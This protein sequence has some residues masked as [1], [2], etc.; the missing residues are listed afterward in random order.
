M[1]YYLSILNKDGQYSHEVVS[2]RVYNY[3][4]QLEEALQKKALRKKLRKQYPNRFPND[5]P[6]EFIGDIEI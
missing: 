1:I 2:E 3:V 4:R 5:E 6:S